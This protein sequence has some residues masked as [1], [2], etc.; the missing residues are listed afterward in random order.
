MFRALQDQTSWEQEYTFRSMEPDV[1][2]EPNGYLNLPDVDPDIF[3]RLCDFLYQGV[4][5]DVTPS[6]VMEKKLYAL[7][8]LLGEHNLMN[9]LVDM[10][11]EYHFRSNTHMTVRQLRCILPNLRGSGIWEYCVMGMAYQLARQLYAANDHEFDKLCRENREVS[12]TLILEVKKHGKDFQGTKDYRRR[13]SENGM[14]FGPCR[15]HVHIPGA[16]CQLDSFPVDY[17]EERPLENNTLF[18]GPY[19][20]E[21]TFKFEPPENVSLMGSSLR[22]RIQRA[23]ARNIS[24]SGGSLRHRITRAPP[25]NISVLGGSLRNRIQRKVPRL[26]QPRIRTA[27]TRVAKRFPKVR[28]PI[29]TRV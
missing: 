1:L 6:W 10:L 29:R 22:H 11:Q 13:S 7:A 4:V 23:P 5:P 26:H 17:L 27:A 3:Q 9:R 8:D 12:E 18:L 24:V 16:T 21:S 2:R 25:E 15:F 28:M 19:P 14:G 20:V